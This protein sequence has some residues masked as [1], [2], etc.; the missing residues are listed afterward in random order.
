MKAQRDWLTAQR[1]A[2]KRKRKIVI[3]G[4]VEDLLDYS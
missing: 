1:K 4:K 2:R 3:G